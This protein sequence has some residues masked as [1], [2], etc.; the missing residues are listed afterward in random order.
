MDKCWFLDEI[1]RVQCNAI[2]WPHEPGKS[3]AN[4]PNA[5]P[6]HHGG[7]T[8]YIANHR[9]S[10]GTCTGPSMFVRETA[11]I[12]GLSQTFLKDGGQLLSQTQFTP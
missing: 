8:L 11:P 9:V 3:Q 1:K 6:R 5:Q 10:A 2:V 4:H 12:M 7:P